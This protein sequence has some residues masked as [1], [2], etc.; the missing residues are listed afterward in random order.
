MALVAL[1]AWVPFRSTEN[2]HD[3]D[4]HYPTV[5]AL[6]LLALLVSLS[7]FRPLWQSLQKQPVMKLPLSITDSQ[8][9][10]VKCELV[11]EI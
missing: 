4:W 10:A 3:P 7:T 9:E 11:F 6:V 2:T 5:I 8:N 1:V